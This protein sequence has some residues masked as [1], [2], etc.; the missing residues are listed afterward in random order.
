MRCQTHSAPTPAELSSRQRARATRPGLVRSKPTSADVGSSM[1][2]SAAAGSKRSASRGAP[3]GD[4]RPAQRKRQAM[5]SPKDALPPA[6]AAPGSSGVRRVP[7][8]LAPWACQACTLDNAGQAASCAACGAPASRALADL[9]SPLLNEPQMVPLPKATPGR[10][11]GGRTGERAHGAEEGAGRITL[12]AAH[13]RRGCT[14]PSAEPT[15]LA[16]KP[17]QTCRTFTAEG[18]AEEVGYGA[19]AAEGRNAGTAKQQDRKSA[20]GR[21]LRKRPAPEPVPS[22]NRS[23]SPGAALA[24]V[25]AAQAAPSSAERAQLGN[26]GGAGARWTSQQAKWVL[27]ASHLSS[28]ELAA[29]GRVAAAAGARMAQR[30]EPSVTHVVCGATAERLAKRTYKFLMGVL[31]RCWVVAFA[32]VAACETAAAPVLEEPFEVSRLSCF[33]RV[34]QYVA[35]MLPLALRRCVTH[36]YLPA[37]KTG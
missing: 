32:W 15:S 35:G 18:H 33:V 34:V 8:R 7:A 16:I 26:S 19:S 21:R 13:G 17:P 6:P 30:W 31:S 1:R 4:L 3:K 22:A 36:L 9:S 11:G 10:Q 12:R 14:G 28:Q 37:K 20:A 27:L 24:P 25:L 29:L 23:A 2:T 5:A